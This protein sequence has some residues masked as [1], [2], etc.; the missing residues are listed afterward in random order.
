MFSLCVKIQIQFTAECVVAFIISVSAIVKSFED[1]PGKDILVWVWS[2]F[3]RSVDY[4]V[5]VKEMN[6]R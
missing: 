6:R 1:F 2:I 5:S 4:I 3:S